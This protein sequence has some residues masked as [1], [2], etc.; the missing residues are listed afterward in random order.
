MIRNCKQCGT[1]IDNEKSQF[2]PECG[3]SSDSTSFNQI[4]II[5]IDSNPV[6]RQIEET[7]CTCS[8]CGN[9]WFFGKKDVSVQQEKNCMMME[10]NACAGACPC[11]LPLAF[12]GNE[13]RY[14]DPDK[15]PKCGSRAIK[16]EQ[17]IHEVE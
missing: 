5:P 1:L 16:K 13:P 17:I 11:C 3:L 4:E 8:G 6:K 12:F 7:K 2:C 10:K 15:C 9:I 14:N